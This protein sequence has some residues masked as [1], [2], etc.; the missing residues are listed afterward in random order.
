MVD[1]RPL[2]TPR[3]HPHP[4]K[5]ITT[6]CAGVLIGALSVVLLCTGF[7]FEGLQSVTHRSQSHKIDALAL[8]MIAA[9]ELLTLSCV[10]ESQC[11]TVTVIGTLPVMLFTRMG[12]PRVEVAII[13]WLVGVGILFVLFQCL[14]LVLGSG[15]HRCI[16]RGD[17][18]TSHGSQT[19][20]DHL[21]SFS[22][23]RRIRSRGG[24]KERTKEPM[25]SPSRPTSA[26]RSAIRVT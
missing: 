13:A 5:A 1:R 2:H 19:I 3:I 17:H 12:A 9:A 26:P 22:F 15:N 23:R 25:S 10:R 20:A 24:R 14:C 8:V 16:I 4:S 21:Q 11:L 7:L 18:N 6:L